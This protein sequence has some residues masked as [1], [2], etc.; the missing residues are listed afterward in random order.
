M[1]VSWDFFKRVTLVLHLSRSLTLKQITEQAEKLHLHMVLC[2]HVH[3]R[4]S[5]FAGVLSPFCF[6]SAYWKN[7]LN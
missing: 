7:S 1:Y 6:W 2:A 5:V 4:P 3:E